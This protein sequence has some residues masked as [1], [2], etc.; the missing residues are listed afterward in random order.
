MKKRSVSGVL[1]LL[2]A[3]FF[4][5]STFIVQSE[6]A[7]VLPT[8]TYLAARSF[9]GAA[10]LF[11]VIALRAAYRRAKKVVPEAACPDAPEEKGAKRKRYLLA[12]G[13]VGAV[14]TVAAIFQ[15]EGIARGATAGEAGFL[16]ALY[17]FVVPLLCFIFYRKKLTVNL[18]V[19]AILMAVGLYCLCIADKGWTAVGAG[20]LFIILS[21]VGYA[22]HILSVDRFKDVDGLWLSAMQFSVVAVV[23]SVLALIFDRGSFARILDAAFPILYAG[24]VSSAVGFT[25]QIYGQKHAPPTL[26]TI[27]MS[28]ES[29]IALLCEWL[30]SLSGILGVARGSVAMTPLKIVGCVF[31]FVGIVAAQLSFGK[32][33]QRARE[34]WRP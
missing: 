30:C 22:F 4:W 13:S 8:F 23:S 7:A 12:G 34:R 10:A 5:G 14:L 20:H 19:G 2:L 17:M 26:A 28:L 27:V 32:I 6:A 16:T 24:L 33:A 11:V 18:L 9:V 15:Q 1:T 21:A 31:A 29:V 3:S 25:L